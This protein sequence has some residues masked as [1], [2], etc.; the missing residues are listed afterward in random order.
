MS[1]CYSPY[2][3]PGLLKTY[4]FIKN[5]SGVEWTKLYHFMVA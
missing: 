5:C 3:T 4:N 2:N 1:V